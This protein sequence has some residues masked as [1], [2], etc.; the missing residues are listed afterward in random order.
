MQPPV[1]VDGGRR[2]LG[3]VVVG[4][5]HVVAPYHDLSGLAPRHLLALVV[6]DQHLDAG[7]GPARGGGDRLGVVIVAAHGG[8]AARLGEAV[9]GDDGLERELPPHAQDELDGDG[10]GAGD[11]QAQRRDV[12]VGEPRV[13]EDGLVEAGWPRKHG[14]A[15]FGDPR[16]HG[17]G[18]EHGVGDDRRPRDQRGDDAGLVAEGMEEGVD[19]E[20]A[21]TRSQADHVGPVGVRPQGLGMGAHGALG[22]P[23]GA[24]RE[25]DVGQVVGP[26]PLRPAHGVGLVHRVTGGEEL[27]PCDGAG[28]RLAPEDDDVLEVGEPV[29]LGAQQIDVVGVEEAGDGEQEPGPALGQDVGG[30][31]ALEAGV[32]G[33]EHGAGRMQAHQGHQPLPDIRRPDGDAVARLHAGGHEGPRRPVAGGG[34]VGE[35]HAH[36]AVDHRFTVT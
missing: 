12:V 13:V 21:V 36:V 27:V 17:G 2:L 4:A 30:L 32:E 6:D 28:G 16:E 9:P 1:G 18:V 15:L 14:D 33:D 23:G 34:Q 11:G 29:A 8:D 25:Q 22:V 19:D 24:R 35:A 7:D 3:L 26:D 20:I 5:H 10:G 31:G